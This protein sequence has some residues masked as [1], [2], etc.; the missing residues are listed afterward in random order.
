MQITGW[1]RIRMFNRTIVKN[2]EEYKL[3]TN[4]KLYRQNKH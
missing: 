3:N 1:V 4:R 2:Q